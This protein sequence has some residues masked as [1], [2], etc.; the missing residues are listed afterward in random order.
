MKNLKILTTATVLLLS[1]FSVQILAQEEPFTEEQMAAYMEAIAPN[2]EHQWLKKFDGKY[3]YEM[4]MSGPGAPEEKSTGLCKREMV[5]GGRYQ[6]MNIRGESSG[7]PFEGMAINAYDKVSEMYLST[8]IDNWGTGILF[9]KGER[10]GN[11]IEFIAPFLNPM[12]NRQETHR[13]VIEYIDDDKDIMDYYIKP[14]DGEEY[15][16]IHTVYTRIRQ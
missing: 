14:E 3:S 9:F 2:Q 15:H 7:M 12:Y 5:L 4:T 11:K 8:W 1:I 13:M 6:V 16:A 10:D